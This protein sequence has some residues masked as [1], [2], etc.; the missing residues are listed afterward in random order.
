M[1]FKTFEMNSLV[2]SVVFAIPI[3]R[4][5]NTN[6]T[7]SISSPPLGGSVLRKSGC[8]A[9]VAPN[10]DS[11]LVPSTAQKTIGYFGMM[12]RAFQLEGWAGLF[13]GFRPN[14]LSIIICYTSLLF[15]L[16]SFR[17]GIP[18]SFATVG[19]SNV[20]T[21]LLATLPGHINHRNFIILT[22]RAIIT[23]YIVLEQHQVAY[24]IAVMSLVLVV[25][26]ISV[27]LQIIDTR[28]SVRRN[29]GGDPPSF[30]MDP[31]DS[32][33]QEY[34]SEQVVQIRDKPYTG[35]ATDGKKDGKHSSENGGSLCCR[36]FSSSDNAEECFNVS[37]ID[38]P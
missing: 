4:P 32:H 10:G 35:M 13:K 18:P 14:L 37:I 23:P 12:K 36:A 19:I 11:L 2:L 34:A 20:I 1:S 30:E 15:F 6:I 22:N 29:F 26:T 28:L 9:L 21:F 17:P 33:L 3:G 25:T 5:G 38:L 24:I 27:P 8:N 31:E 7:K 16:V